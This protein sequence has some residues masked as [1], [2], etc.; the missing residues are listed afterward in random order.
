M[1]HSFV[2]EHAIPRNTQEG[3]KK[4]EAMGIRIYVHDPRCLL[5]RSSSHIPQYHDIIPSCSIS[6]M[7]ILSAYILLEIQYPNPR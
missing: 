2:P 1:V 5:C 3:A 4:G 7:R 6:R